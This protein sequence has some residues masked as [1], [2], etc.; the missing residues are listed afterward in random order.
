[1]IPKLVFTAFFIACINLCQAQQE[2]THLSGDV[3]VTLIKK[4]LTANYN[5]TNI[6]LNSPKMSFMLHED[7]DVDQVYLNGNPIA[8]SKNGR[9]C[10]TCKVHTIWIDRA[11]TAQD[12]LKITVEG[13]LENFSGKDV[14]NTDQSFEVGTAS[15]WYPVILDEQAKESDAPFASN[16]YAYTYDLQIKG[17][18]KTVRLVSASAAD[19]VFKSDVANTDIHLFLSLQQLEQQTSSAEISLNNTAVAQPK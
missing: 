3:T 7:F 12:T 4:V 18:P 14:V 2:T 11:L 16:S 17:D 15:K 10:E 5:L 9:S 6:T 8:S 19:N 13:D 1:M